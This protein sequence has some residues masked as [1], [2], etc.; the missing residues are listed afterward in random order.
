[1]SNG[2]V[3]ISVLMPVYNTHLYELRAAIESIL[4]QTFKDFEFIIINDG[5]TA[6]LEN[7]IL[8]YKDERIRYY[9]NE[10][11][12]KLI[13]TLN[14][15]IHLS[16]GKYIARLDADDFSAPERLEKQFEYMEAHPDVGLLGTCFEFVPN[17]FKWEN[18]VDLN[19]L[20][21]CIRY[22]PGCLL[23]SSAMIR[24]SV[25][26]ENALYYDKNCLHAEDFKMWA[27]I[28]R[29]SKV[30]MLPEV[31]TYYRMSEDGICAKNRKFQNKMLM[32]I[33]LGNMIIDFD[34][35][36]TIMGEILNKYIEDSSLSDEEYIQLQNF[37]AKV[38]DEI[39]E[40]IS[41]ELHER[42]S[43]Y[44]KAILAHAF[45]ENVVPMVSVLM[46]V[47]NARENELRQSIESILNQTFTDFEFIIINDGSTNNAEDVILSYGDRRIRYY[48]NEMNIKIIASLNRGLKL[49]RGKYIAR[50]D[51]DD[52]SGLTRLE[53]QVAYMEAHP[54]VGGLGTF[55]KRLHTGEEIALPID[56]QDVTLLTRYVKG[57]I[58]NPSGMIRRSVIVENNLEYNKNCLHA[59][60]FKF[61]ADLSY[62]S[63]LAVI[64]EVLTFIRSHEDGVSKTNFAY[65]SKMVVIVLLDNIIKDFECNK[66]YLYSILVKYIKGEALSKQEFDDMARHLVKVINYLSGKVS[67]SYKPLV[68]NNILS[69]LKHFF[70]DLN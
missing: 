32:N 21:I 3:K 64:P 1:M 42:I 8:S 26:D 41:L 10:T 27:D 6:E 46:S 33:A 38:T 5:S 68:K 39:N 14:K 51:S 34:C 19:D 52:Y 50:L 31:L 16:R 56:P 54:D 47:Y 12:L 25:L 4:N 43:N 40:K 28:S 20:N 62:Y 59:E 29:L 35:D 30:A 49:C 67:E 58:S 17:T 22:I 2:L 48:E 60:D 11:N 15:G 61:W 23:H 66:D 45:N 7:I 70:V 44:T 63:D 55:F 57:C 9:K 37:L 36:K 18:I 69:L 24:K 53:K 65:Q 13:A